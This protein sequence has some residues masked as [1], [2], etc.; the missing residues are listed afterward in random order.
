VSEASSNAST[1]A[2]L[3]VRDLKVEYARSTGAVLVLDGVDLT[4]NR[5]ESLGVVGESGVGKT[6]LV[7]TILGLLDPPWRVTS[8]TV[9][10]RGQN[11]LA[12]P[13]PALREL[14]GKEI[15]LTTHDPRKHLNPVATI[16]DQ[17]AR[18]VQ[19]HRPASRTDARARAI[20]LLRLVGIPDPELR[21]QAYPHELSGGMCQRVVIAMAL[22][23]SP[24]LLMGDEPTAGLDVTI[25]LQILDLMRDLVRDF[26]SSLLL[27]SRDLGVVAHYCQRVAVMYAGQIVEVADVPTF[28]AGAIHPYS[29]RLLRAAVAATSDRGGTLSSIGSHAERGGPSCPYAPRC[30]LCVERCTREAP[31]LEPVARAR[32]V[33]CFRHAEITAGLETP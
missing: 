14:R 12:L 18:V 24:K 20:E 13:E 10:Y 7:R 22:A 5:G 21:L 4:I 27:V 2:L 33:R 6:V 9:S 25:S 31:A 29:R 15:A 3:E 19:A 30:P 23:H 26:H 17:M 28:F 32:W 1:D 8:G 16:G 11:L